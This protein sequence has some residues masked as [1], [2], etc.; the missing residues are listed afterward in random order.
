MAF[1]EPTGAFEDDPNLTNTKFKGNPTKSFRSRT[2]L[3]VI[4]EL[5]QWVGHPPEA[6]RAMKEGLARLEQAG[7]EPADE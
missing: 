7:V 1:V 5:E 4:S 6:I 2:P 3:R